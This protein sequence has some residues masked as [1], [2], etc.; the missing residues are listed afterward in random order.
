[1]PPTPVS[2]L[3]AEEDVRFRTEPSAGQGIELWPSQSSDAGEPIAWALIIAL[4]LSATIL[5]A[6]ALNQQLWFDEIIM[7]L[8]RHAN[9]CGRPLRSTTGR[10]NTCS[11]RFWRT[12]PLRLFGEHA[13]ALRLPAMLF[14]IASIPTPH[15]FARLVTTNREALLASGL[16]AINYQ[17]IWFSQNARGY[18]GMAYFAASIFFIRSARVGRLEIG[19]S[20]VL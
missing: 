7:L 12:A 10:I 14:G 3:R 11:I 13:W 16:M 4:V 9:P 2:P 15:L 1:M 19:C 5:R 17:H 6:I 18:T 8:T 20:T